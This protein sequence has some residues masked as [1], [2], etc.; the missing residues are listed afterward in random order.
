MQSLLPISGFVFNKKFQRNTSTFAIFYIYE[1]PKLH[2]S[3]RA[4]T[5]FSFM[6]ALV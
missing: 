1:N 6:N 3:F 4:W 2:F 5:L